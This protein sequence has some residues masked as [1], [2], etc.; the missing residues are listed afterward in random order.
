LICRT[1][2]PIGRDIRE[3]LSLFCNIPVEAVIEEQDVET[4][5][6][7]LPLALAQESLDDLVVDM[8][9]LD[10]PDS[11]M[12]VWKSVVRRLKFPANRVDIGVVGKYI[13]LQDAYKSVYESLSHGGIANDCGIN[14]IRLDSE[15]IE[16]D[17]AEAH[18]KN[19]HGVLVPGGFGARGIEGK[20]AAAAYAR[21]KLVPYFGLCLGMQIL[22]IEFARHVAGFPGA[23]STEFDEGCDPAIIDLM[24]DQRGVVDKGATMRLGSWPCELQPDTLA[25]KAY[26]QNRQS[27]GGEFIIHERHRHRFEFNNEHRSILERS[28]LRI[29][30]VNPERKLVEIVE[31][32]DHPWM[33]GVQYHP[34]FKSKPNEAHPLFAA[35][36]KAAMAFKSG[37]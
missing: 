3:K 12:A 27:P 16:E 17:G 19:L 2:Q 36:I 21:E 35:F 7:E 37:R 20:I 25:W 15:A 18:L 1:E 13:E 29:G 33:L 5:I 4:S 24:H 14:I 34:E 9:Q 31:V 26:A 22:A 32:F 28:G 30:G 23:N 8:L 6:Y 11:D 10:A